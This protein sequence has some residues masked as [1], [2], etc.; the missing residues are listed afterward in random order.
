[1]PRAHRQTDRAYSIASMTRRS[2][3]RT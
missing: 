2:S 1:M 3:G